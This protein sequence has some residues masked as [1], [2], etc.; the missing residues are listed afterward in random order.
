MSSKSELEMALEY[1]EYLAESD[2]EDGRALQALWKSLEEARARRASQDLFGSSGDGSTAA[3]PLRQQSA[4]EPATAF[5]THRGASRVGSSSSSSGA[6]HDT[7]GS[8]DAGSS[9]DAGPSAAA[10]SSDDAKTEVKGC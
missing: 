7:V 4:S 6:A 8:M 2:D 9:A 10:A 3:S 5:V 1:S